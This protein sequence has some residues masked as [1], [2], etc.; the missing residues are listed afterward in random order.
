MG[1][2]QVRQVSKWHSY[3]AIGAPLALVAVG[4]QASGAE[5]RE[6]LAYQRTGIAAGEYWRL[7]SG[8]LVHLGWSHLGYNLAG[9]VLIGWLVGR[10]F[11]LLRWAC[12]VAV[13]IVAINIGF[14]FL[15]PE[16]AWYVGLSGVLH[17]LLAGGILAGLLSRN[18]EAIVLAVF[19]LGK[20]AWEQWAGPI[21][22][23]ASA[24]GGAVIVDAHLYGAVGGL[25]A[26]AGFWRRVG[27]R[28][29]I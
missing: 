24:S 28:A 18:R 27:A 25:L 1:L 9:L 6:A 10:S 13:S 8:H 3:L 2:R 15:N 17:G 23:S 22:G 20:L 5:V 14:W 11:D 26:A 16:L 29:S 7:L 19:L 12:I 21:P 4:L